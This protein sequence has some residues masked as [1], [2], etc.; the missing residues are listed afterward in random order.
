MDSLKE[1]LIYLISNYGVFTTI[2]LGMILILL[3]VFS[4]K[5]I[6]KVKNF[7]LNVVSVE[8]LFKHN[9]EKFNK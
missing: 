5:I 6:E 1:L 4:G 3:Y 2:V 8:T 7:I 9:P